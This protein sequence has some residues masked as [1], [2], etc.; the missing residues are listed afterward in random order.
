[1][2]YNNRYYP[3]QDEVSPQDAQWL[4]GMAY[5]PYSSGTDFGFALRNSLNNLLAHKQGQEEATQEQTRY[6]EEQR[7]AEAKVLREEAKAAKE[8]QL[9]EKKFELD[10]QKAKF[11]MG[12]LPAEPA[13]IIEAKALMASDPTT[14]P[15]L[16]TALNTTLKIKPEKT[17]VQIEGEATARARGARKGNPPKPSKPNAYEMKKADIK[18]AV[19][20]RDITPEEGFRLSLG[21]VKDKDDAMKGAAIRQANE[22]AVADV[23]NA[24]DPDGEA[25]DSAKR[26]GGAIP[27]TTEGYRMDMPRQYSVAQKN[28]KD[29]ADMTGDDK[30]IVEKYDAMYNYF[31]G[32]IAPKYKSFG[33]W[34]KNSPNSKRPEFDLE[35]IRKWFKIYVR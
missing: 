31:I 22:K 26:T 27:F 29:G 30:K 3:R 15:T 21:I 18:A 19:K 28:I 7:R 33:D 8:A 35:R 5:N 20:R 13:S 1:M 16:G 4:G 25:R 2:P 11:D 23:F 9:A 10:Q 17:L 14:Y 32:K 6:D 12:K 24:A 34:L